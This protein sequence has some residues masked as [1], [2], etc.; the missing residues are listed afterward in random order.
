MSAATFK[1]ER[2]FYER[3]AQDAISAN[4]RFAEIAAPH[5]D[6]EHGI[7]IMRGD[8]PSL[9]LTEQQAFRIAKD[10]AD[11]LTELRTKQAR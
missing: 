2:H 4:I 1:T 3:N 5:G 10:I 9:I 6:T 7:A 8:K 11:H